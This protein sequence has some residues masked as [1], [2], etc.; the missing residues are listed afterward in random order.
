[1]ASSLGYAS[2]HRGREI[3][4]P[5][6]G[7]HYNL[8]WLPCTVGSCCGMAGSVIALRRCQ[9]PR[10]RVGFTRGPSASRGD[11]LHHGV[12]DSS[13]ERRPTVGCAVG[14]VDEF[15]APRLRIEMGM[16][17]VTV[18]PSPVKLGS[19][20]TPSSGILR[21][22]APRRGPG[23]AQRPRIKEY[24]PCPR[25]VTTSAGSLWAWPNPTPA[26]TFTELS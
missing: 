26:T 18:R 21:L 4:V 24:Q 8:D 9:T 11:Y 3:D 12:I 19:V 7:R 15:P 2:S 22:M 10:S 5:A 1:M 23:F 6:H 17:T 14:R 13:G 16:R 20:I 25:M